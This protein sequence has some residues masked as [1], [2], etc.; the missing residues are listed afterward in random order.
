MVSV[1]RAH[2]CY[3][4]LPGLGKLEKPERYFAWYQPNPGARFVEPQ[5]S[6]TAP[7][8]LHECDA[9]GRELAQRDHP[10]RPYPV[11]SY[12]KAF[13][14]LVTPMT[15]VA[16][17]VRLSQSLRWEGR[18]KR[19]THQ[20]VILDY[21]ENMRYFV[22]GTSRFEVTPGALIPGYVALILVSAAASALG[23]FVLARRYAFS[24]ARGIGW[25]LLGLFF[26]WVG[27]VLMLVL[28]EWP[29]RVSCPNCC[30]LRVAT[31]DTCEYCGALHQPPAHDGTEILEASATV[32][33]VALT[34]S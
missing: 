23:C 5:E 7:F 3:G 31:R 19:S 13:F 18:S 15:E 17:L 9:G 34:A 24:R 16:T 26:G 33:Q 27:L 30:K 20:P 29:A 4:Y 25:A 10:Q 11:A 21:L 6:K 2:D 32:E 14:G 8:H 28:Q 22:P 12:A 1:P